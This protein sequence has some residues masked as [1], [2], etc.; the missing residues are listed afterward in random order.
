MKL[1]GGICVIP[2]QTFKGSSNTIIYKSA[3]SSIMSGDSGVGTS[4]IPGPN[5]SQSSGN[6][7]SSTGRKVVTG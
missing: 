1:G 6:S 5:M 3:A 7:G 2:L 4:S